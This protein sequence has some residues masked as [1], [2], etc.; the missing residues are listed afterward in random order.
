M[1]GS[2]WSCCWRHR[3]SNA[4]TAAV[5]FALTV[6]LLVVVA[7]GATDYGNMANQQAALEGATHAGAEYA[8]A[9]CAA[10]LTT[11]S[12]SA[13]R[14]GTQSAVT[15]FTPVSPPFTPSVTAVCTCAD[16][17]PT[18]DGTCAGTCSVGT[19]HDTR[20]IQYVSVTA[21][22][23]FAPIVSY[24]TF[25]FPPSLSAGTVTRIQ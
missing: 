7:L 24:V 3:A 19:P 21:T 15:S 6:P 14:P 16:N 22:Q 9:K 1:I 2:L 18:S 20:V 13:C 5:E 8:R 10:P 23:T 4:G 12:L 17:S 11:A 25:V